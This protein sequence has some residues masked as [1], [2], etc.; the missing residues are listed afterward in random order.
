MLVLH[1]KFKEVITI[2]SDME[3]KVMRN[4]NECLMFELK[5]PKD[6][7]VIAEYEVKDININNIFAFKIKYN[8]Q[9][10]INNSIRIK[11]FRINNYTSFKFCIDAPREILIFREK[12][13][14]KM[15]QD[16]VSWK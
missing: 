6:T 7:V 15:D 3:M 11:I 1:V 9:I 2:G 10:Y 5:A 12:T 4:S 13:R 14:K 16:G 8:H